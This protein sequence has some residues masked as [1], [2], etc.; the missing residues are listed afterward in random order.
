[1]GKN[2]LFLIACLITFT[3]LIHAQKKLKSLDTIDFI[4][5]DYYFFTLENGSKILAYYIGQPTDDYIELETA[6]GTIIKV[7]K[8]DVIKVFKAKPQNMVDGEYWHENS[9]AHRYMVSPSAFNLSK[10]EGIWYNGY[11]FFNALEYGVNKYFNIKVGLNVLHYFNN[12]Y[13][14]FYYFAAKLGNIKLYDKIHVGTNF[15]HINNYG[16]KYY[17]INPIITL[18]SPNN[19]MTLGWSSFRYS[20]Y[21]HFFEFSYTLQ[22][23]DSPQTAGFVNLNAMFR[24]SRSMYLITENWLSDHYNFDGFNYLGV[25][26]ARNLFGMDMGIITSKEIR[27]EVEFIGLPYITLNY[28]F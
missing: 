24:L 21:G 15:F 6:L 9:Y 17:N 27:D 20:G 13:E 11:G 4:K 28:K 5:D 26:Y 18:G 10:N 2:K 19:N 3:A 7:H 8:D 16:K 22:D 23:S 12:E 1:M 14:S 25:R